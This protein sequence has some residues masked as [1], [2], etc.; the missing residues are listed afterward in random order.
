MW[1]PEWVENQLFG[2]TLSGRPGW[3]S[4]NRCTVTPWPTSAA[5]T[6][7]TSCR[8]DAAMVFARSGGTGD[9]NVLSAAVAGLGSK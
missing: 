8:A 6:S 2:K 3:S 5:A 1:P 4:S 9:W 7:V